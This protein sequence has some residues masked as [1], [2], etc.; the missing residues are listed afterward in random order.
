MLPLPESCIVVI[1]PVS[2][3]QSV[4]VENASMKAEIRKLRIE[5]NDLMK[6]VRFADIN[7]Q[8]MR[9]RHI[10]HEQ[11]IDHRVR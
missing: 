5:N 1:L 2:Y 8:Y 9:V 3:V 7:A 10:E 4:I 6:R 11:M